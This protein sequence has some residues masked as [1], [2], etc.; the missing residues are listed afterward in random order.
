S[1][2]PIESYSAAGLDPQLEAATHSYLQQETQVDTQRGRVV[3]PRLLRIYR[4]DFGDRRAQLE[5]IA[6]RAPQVS[7]LLH[8]G[9][10]LA[11]RYASF[12]WT[13]AMPPALRATAR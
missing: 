9:R 3:L 8:S 13:V 5:F 10:R 4:Q 11:V 12:D 7:E 6:A 2:P 1:C